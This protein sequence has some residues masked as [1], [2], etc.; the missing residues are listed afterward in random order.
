MI[1]TSVIFLAVRVVDVAAVAA[2]VRVGLVLAE[3]DRG[4]GESVDRIDVRRLPL[5]L[6]RRVGHPGGEVFCESEGLA[7]L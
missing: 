7:G 2:C 3:V 4:V 5:R 6:I 1:L